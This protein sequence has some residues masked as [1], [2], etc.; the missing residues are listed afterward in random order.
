MKH[1]TEEY[2]QLCNLLELSEEEYRVLDAFLRLE[3]VRIRRC[4]SYRGTATIQAENPYKSMLAHCAGTG[5]SAEKAYRSA[6]EEMNDR[7]VARYQR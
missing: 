7:Q 5:Y 3:G 4:R 2:G 6:E 1:I